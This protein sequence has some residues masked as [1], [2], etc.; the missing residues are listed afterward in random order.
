MQ[1]QLNR[2]FGLCTVLH[3]DMLGYETV[4]TANI[5]VCAVRHCFTL[6]TLPE[7]LLSAA[8]IATAYSSAAAPSLLHALLLFCSTAALLL[9][10]IMIVVRRSTRG[11]RKL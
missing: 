9:I 6:F 1:E 4:S 8:K 5:E 7:P 10:M 3:G 11:H 2:I